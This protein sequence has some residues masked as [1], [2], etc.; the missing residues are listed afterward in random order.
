MHDNYR[1]KKTMAL[2]IHLPTE[3]A[4]SFGLAAALAAAAGCA[5]PGGDVAYTV[6][7]PLFEVS[8][9]KT[10]D[11]AKAG[12]TLVF[13]DEFEGD[14]V[15]TNKWYRPHFALKEPTLIAP[16]GDGHLVFHMT[17]DE[18]GKL[19]NGYLFSVP[20][21][22]C[23]YYEAR[24]KFTTEP[25]WWSAS[26]MYGGSNQN[27]FMDGIEIDTVEDFY[28][29][30]RDGHFLKD[31]MAHSIHMHTGSYTSSCQLH[32]V[33]EGP[34]DGW[35]TIACKW[36]PLSF[37]F[38]LD[39]RLTGS[40]SAFN[41]GT[42]IRP[43]HAILSTER[44]RLDMDKWMG[45]NAKPG[46]EEGTYEVDWVRIWR[47]ETADAEAPEVGWAPE[48][49]IFRV[50]A[51]TGS[52]EQLDVAA[53]S[54]FADDPI[55]QVYLFDNGYAIAY[56]IE[57]PG[58]FKVPLTAEY[59]ASSMY[60]R[61]RCSHSLKRPKFD[62]YPHVFVA[63]A[64]TKSG[65]VG[66]SA[67]IYRIP[68]GEKPA[69]SPYDDVPAALPGTIYA[70]RFDGG[71]QGCGYYRTPGKRYSENRSLCPRPEE[72][73]D[74]TKSQVGVTYAGE[75][76]NYT[77]DVAKRGTYLA[78]FRYGTAIRS[79]NEALLLVDGRLA[80]S[81]A[82][83]AE[84]VTKWTTDLKSEAEVQLERGRHVITL[85]LRSQ[86]KFAGIDFSFKE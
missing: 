84:A 67:P 75:W 24:V 41:A 57:P 32:T 33:V 58:R 71:G 21:Y 51:A 28:T 60:G 7:E 72:Q 14:E 12:W 10:F 34:V 36:D 42:C 53:K 65:R 76:L 52:V 49:D 78:T 18:T 55:D 61:F 1:N 44:R 6:A 82:L 81:F 39:G 26:W 74:C 16:D 59:F 86:L 64:R 66:H 48:T 9:E 29:R 45:G 3:I 20:E 38:Y 80:G 63:F 5:K 47:N 17:K 30:L 70:W 62:A 54:R 11:P 56:S 50:F 13:E 85:L 19:P 73:V 4:L 79:A 25:G 23:G 37:S 27:P 69:S 68:A 43:L 83:P 2:N 46:S 22:E 77:V 35:H 40:F 8:H 15:D 31:R